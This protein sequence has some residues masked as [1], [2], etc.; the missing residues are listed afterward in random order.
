VLAQPDVREIAAG[1][2][3]STVD[4]AQVVVKEHAAFVRAR[5]V[6]QRGSVRIRNSVVPRDLLRGDAQVERDLLDILLPDRYNR[7]P[8]TVRAS[9]AVYVA[10][11][12]AGENLERLVRSMPRGEKAA[13]GKVFLGLGG[14]KATDFI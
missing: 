10:A 4:H 6:P 9:G 8:A 3:A 1:L 11:D 14:S 2:R 5:Q 12:F 7:V 13:E